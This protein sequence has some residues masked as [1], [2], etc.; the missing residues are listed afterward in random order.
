MLENI[1]FSKSTITL[2]GYIF[3]RVLWL[4][5]TKLRRLSHKRSC[6]YSS[7]IPPLWRWK[8]RRIP[9]D[10]L[11]MPLSVWCLQQHNSTP[12]ITLSIMPSF[13]IR[14]KHQHPSS[15]G[16]CRQLKIHVLYT[17]KYLPHFS[18]NTQARRAL[19]SGEDLE[20]RDMGV[21]WIVWLD[22][23]LHGEPWNAHQVL[24]HYYLVALFCRYS[25]LCYS[26]YLVDMGWYCAVLG[27]AS[28]SRRAIIPSASPAG[29]AS[30]E[31]SC[32]ERTP[33]ILH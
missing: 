29:S 12:W 26:L 5:S 15:L 14:Y 10:Y 25:L 18:Y 32:Q 27:W 28:E 16:P 13:P 19:E 21:V 24:I 7:C 23:G 3:V 6:L 2:E 9:L 1:V 4:A 11:S 17:S 20:W 8:W 33:E 30:P 22:R 31:A